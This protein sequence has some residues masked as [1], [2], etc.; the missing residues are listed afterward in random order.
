MKLIFDNHIKLSCPTISLQKKT[1][2]QAIL[3]NNL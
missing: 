1:E 2:H 3:Q